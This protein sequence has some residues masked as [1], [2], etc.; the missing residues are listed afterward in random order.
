MLF[1]SYSPSFLDSKVLLIARAG[2]YFG[3]VFVSDVLGE[4]KICNKERVIP[5]SPSAKKVS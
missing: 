4:V 5:T 1:S 2:H 3:D